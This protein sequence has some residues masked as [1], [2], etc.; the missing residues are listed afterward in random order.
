[1]EQ[2][3]GWYKL[4]H[5][6]WCFRGHSTALHVNMISCLIHRVHLQYSMWNVF[7]AVGSDQYAVYTFIEQFAF[8]ILQYAMC[9][10]A[11]SSVQCTVYVH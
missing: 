4:F 2:E 1:M 9:T 6:K 7:S 10:S 8:F 11:V 3:N 5:H